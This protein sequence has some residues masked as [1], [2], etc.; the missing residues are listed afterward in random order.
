MPRFAVD[1]HRLALGSGRCG[2]PGHDIRSRETDAIQ[3]EQLIYARL[4]ELEAVAPPP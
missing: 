1:P 4:I 3:S 2:D